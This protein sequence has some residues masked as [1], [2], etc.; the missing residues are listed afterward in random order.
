MKLGVCTSI[1]NLDTAAR[2]GFDYIECSLAAV[3]QMP[4]DAFDALAARAGDFPIPVLKCNCFLPAEMKPVGPDVR[5]A[6]LREY[7]ET[8]LSRAR[9]LGVELAVFGSGPARRVPEGWSF[10][11]AW[12]Q[13]AD[14]LRLAAD[15][16][17]DYGITVALEPLR[18]RECNLLNLVSEAT[19]L[20]GLVN[21]PRIAA[22]GDT[23]H[24]RSV[25]EPWDALAHA[26]ETLAHVHISHT[27]P[28]L[29]GR[30]FC[31]ADD[32]EDYAEI[33]RVLRGM[34]YRGDVSV[35]ASCRDL[36]ADGAAALAC[37]GPLAR[38]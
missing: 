15:T 35:E 20:C 1:D 22:L 6:A 18:R 29:S 2:L 27:L 10:A 8:A 36:E 34:G 38:A 9:R 16:A 21:H 28:D 12:E 37:L 14:F 23:F 11:R 3:A 30:V 4:R 33:F 5:E 17:D 26:G 31:R 19:L 32:G 7:L 24:M 25:H 13:L